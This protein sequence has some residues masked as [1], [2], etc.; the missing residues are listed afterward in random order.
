MTILANVDMVDYVADQKLGNTAAPSLNSS[1]A[2][3]MVER[4][5]AHGWYKHPRLG[6]KGHEE[7]GDFDKGTAVHAALL[8]GLDVVEVLDFPDWRTKLAREARDEARANGKIPLL[9]EDAGAVKHMVHVAL[10]A[11][12]AS[13]DLKGLGELVPEQTILWQGPTGSYLR[14]RPDWVTKDRAICL[15]Y[16]TTTNAEPVKFCRTLFDLGYDMQGAFELSGLRDHDVANGFANRNQ[17]KYVWIAQETTAPYAVSLIGMGPEV[18]EYAY[19]RMEEAERLWAACL[20]AGKWPSYSSRILYPETPPWLRPQFAEKS[21]RRE[22]PTGVAKFG[23]SRVP[24]R[25]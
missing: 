11:I 20:K 9:K 3:V 15:S 23:Q 4:S 2:H 12:A 7:R 16:K 22:I 18:E 5:A 17:E 8:E 24:A 1:V 19:G 13:P 6:G 25:A 14:C 10:Q 21:E